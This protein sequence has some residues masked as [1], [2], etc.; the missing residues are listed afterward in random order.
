M[1]YFL[2]AFLFNL[3]F[4]HTALA[5]EE[6]L[7]MSLDPDNQNIIYKE[8]V[9][10]EGTKNE[11][12]NRGS[13]WL[14]IFYANPMA[15][16]RVRDQASGLIR[17]QHPFRVHHVD[18]NGNKVDGEMILYTFKIEFKDGRYR[19]SV[20]DFLVKRI[21]RY[22]LE[23]WLNK[24]DPDYNPKWDEYLRQVDDYVRREWIPSLKSNMKPEIK[25]VE[26]EW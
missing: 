9:Q 21:S 19:Y 6:L 18:E 12:F 3:L 22:P 11:L 2:A 23:N 13:T 5:Q 25:K 26:E 8:V 4:F 20:Y 16:S 15:V 17:G 24:E 7:D 10:E 1:K 14:R